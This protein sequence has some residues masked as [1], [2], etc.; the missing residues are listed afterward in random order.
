M[1]QYAPINREL[2][3]EFFPSAECIVFPTYTMTQE[4]RIPTLIFSRGKNCKAAKNTTGSRVERE[5]GAVEKMTGTE[6]V[7]VLL[8]KSI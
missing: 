8:Q 6:F 1:L 3:V 2:T 4:S 5:K 7:T